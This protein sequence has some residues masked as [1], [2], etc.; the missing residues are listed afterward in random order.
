MRC[1]EMGEGVGTG[2]RIFTAGLNKNQLLV[3]ISLN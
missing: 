2:V 1:N 3:S